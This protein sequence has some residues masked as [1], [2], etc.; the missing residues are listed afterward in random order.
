MLWWAN[1][2]TYAVLLV[3]EIGKKKIKENSLEATRL[4]EIKQRIERVLM[5]R[6]LRPEMVGIKKK[7]DKAKENFY[8]DVFPYEIVL[9]LL[10]K[11]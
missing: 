11:K 1:K 10:V 6:L 5:Y 8:A 3:I 2:K 9:F 4:A 7:P